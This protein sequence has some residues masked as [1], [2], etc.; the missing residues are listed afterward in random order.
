MFDVGWTTLEFPGGRPYSM[1]YD[2]VNDNLYVGGYGD[3]YKLNLNTMGWSLVDSDP[4]SEILANA[5]IISIC[6]DKLGSIYA[7]CDGNTQSYFSNDDGKTWNPIMDIKFTLNSVLTIKEGPDGKIWFGTNNGL[8]V[9]PDQGAT[10]NEFPNMKRS[11][12]SI[13]F[14]SSGNIFVGTNGGLYLST[15]NGE[16]WT[17]MNLQFKGSVIS[18]IGINSKSYIY[19]GSSTYLYRSTNNGANWES[20]TPNGQVGGIVTALDIFCSNDNIIYYAVNQG[21]YITPDECKTWFFANP[22][23]VHVQPKSIVV[24]KSNRIF[25][26]NNLA[27]TKPYFATGKFISTNVEGGI[28]EIPTKFILHQN[29]PNP[30]NPTTRIKFGL[31]NSVLTK[32]IIYDIL[33]S[34]VSVLLN[35]ELEA[36]YHEVNF[37]ATDLPTGIYFYKIQAGEFIQTKKMVLIK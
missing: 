29:Y 36:G 19:A 7:G 31:P 12:G 25:A 34:E 28:S 35:K 14:T 37:D 3:L 18:A 13:G 30:F 24:D 10:Y 27:T 23:P 2:K 15:N 11:I 20:L 17:Q 5:K 26:I 9:S 21:L 32:L 6:R 22:S 16:T 4:I 1:F 8:I 33:G